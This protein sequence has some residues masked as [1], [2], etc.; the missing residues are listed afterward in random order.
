ME[1]IKT[2]V[3]DYLKSELVAFQKSK[4]GYT[5][6]EL[7][8]YEKVLIWKYTID[9]YESLNDSLRNGKGHRFEE[10]LNQT[11]D[12][13]PD[14]RGI[15]FRGCQLTTNEKQFYLE[16]FEKETP[17]LELAFISSSKSRETANL[18]SFGD[19]IF[20][21]YSLHGKSIEQLSFHGVQ[22]PF[23]EKEVLFRSKTRFAV[24]DFVT[25]NRITIITIEELNND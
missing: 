3:E 4:L 8:D 13:L 2:Y 23:N 19:T 15:V 7:S 20:E 18:F 22:S 21:I 24:L 1:E 14:H 6:T 16:A 12:K 5:I 25:T 11:L 9:G 17:F 10:W